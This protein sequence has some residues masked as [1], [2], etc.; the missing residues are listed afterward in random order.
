MNP[1][2]R[3]DLIATSLP[4]VKSIAVRLR[5]AYRFP[6]PIEDLYADGLTGLME[7]VERFDPTRG[8]AFT[9]FA[10]PRI[11]GAILD[12]H[13]HEP[14]NTVYRHERRRRPADT[15]SVLGV[16]STP[17][18]TADAEPTS[19]PAPGLPAFEEIGSI[20]FVPSDQL[21]SIADESALHPDEEVERKRHIERVR[22]AFAALEQ[23][24]RRVLEL[25]YYGEKSFAE[26]AAEIGI[27]KPWAFRIHKRGVRTLRN[28]LQPLDPD[29]P[30][31][32]TSVEDSR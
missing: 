6:S 4:L 9:T 28:A 11:R 27:C 31:S 22:A 7:A 24:E 14:A 21:D 18:G 26:I 12:L 29:M 5:K 10:F 8:V 23:L 32:N 16:A 17:S 2:V 19:T 3:E 1:S 25:H 13:R 30:P 15:R 20:V